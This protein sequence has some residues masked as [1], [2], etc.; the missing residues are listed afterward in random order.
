MKPGDSQP[1]GK[2]PPQV[3]PPIHGERTSQPLILELLAN[4]AWKTKGSEKIV[5][6]TEVAGGLAKN[7]SPKKERS[8]GDTPQQRTV[9]ETGNPE[10]CPT[11]WPRT[12]QTQNLSKTL[13]RTFNL[14]RRLSSI[15][16]QTFKETPT[17][18]MNFAGFNMSHKQKSILPHPAHQFAIQVLLSSTIQKASLLELYN[19]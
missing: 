18:V 1:R 16:C 4:Y 7:R 5:T 6:E 19:S 9:Q 14:T 3:S 2:P 15:T 10:A 12:F 13:P 8:S 17:C 11:T